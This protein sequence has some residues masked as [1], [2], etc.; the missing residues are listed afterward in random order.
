MN[1]NNPDK[2]TNPIKHYVGKILGLKYFYI[3]SLVLF[4][5]GAHFYN[6]YSTKVYEVNSTI[7]P[8]KESR[9]TILASDN[10]FGASN[11]I[12]PRR[13]I[14]DDVNNLSSYSLIAKTLD[15]LNFEIAYY[16][17]NQGFLK[18]TSEIYEMA[19]FKVT[20][21]KS[22]T[23]PIGCRMYVYPISDSTYLLRVPEQTVNLYNYIDDKV[24]QEEL[25]LKI[26]TLGYY[27]RT[28]TGNNFSF[29]IAHSP[30]G[31]P[32]DTNREK[33]YFFRFFHPDNLAMSYLNRLD[34]RPISF[35]ASI[36]ELHFQGENIDKSITFLNSYI[37]AFMEENLAK[38]NK[39]ALNTVK[40]IDSQLSE[41]S[42]SLVASESMLRNFRSDNQVTDLGFQGERI[43][44]Q[45]DQIDQERSQLEVRKRYFEYVINYFKT[46]NDV[47]GVVPPV[48]ANIT[49]PIMNDLITE[50]LD[51]NS[52]R[53][54]LLNS[55][56][57][58]NLYLNQIEN[59]IRLQKELI[60]EN[61]RNNLNTLNLSINELE[62]REDKLSEEISRLPRTEMNMVGIERKFN[63][64]DAI[65]TFLLEKRSEAAITL[66][67]NFPDYEILEAARFN[68]SKVI[69]PK[70]RTNYMLAFML[71]L[72]VP[73]VY[74]LLR[75]MFDD[76][77]NSTWDLSARS[78]NAVLNK[79]YS[80]KL[81][82]E[83]VFA[84]A[85]SSAIAESFRSMRSH[86]IFKLK[87]DKDKVILVTSSQ[88][89]DGKSFISYN[90][91]IALASVGYKTAIVDSDLRRPTMHR[92]FGF[93]NE[94]GIS[95]YMSNSTG[96][97]E[98]IRETDQENLSV[99]TAGPV[100][101]NASE[102]IQKGE[103]DKLFEYLKSEFDYIIIDSSP[104]G[105]VSDA[106]QLL[107]Y[108]NRVAVVARNKYT[109]KSTFQTAIETLER[110][111]VDD[112]DIVFNDLDIK[113]S[114]YATY[115]KYYTKN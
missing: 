14:E 57:E 15:K 83:N 51:L 1:L 80:N 90:L 28:L 85:P 29:S 49:D 111:L 73:S 33:D 62:Y 45:L 4:L 95:T 94:K 66:A 44:D 32:A 41:I 71:G 8:V 93:E 109:R 112:Y 40:F 12:A 27:N 48:S 105:L 88:P 47:K 101:P 31:K 5:A 6:K 53:S 97:N 43:Y 69:K 59:K 20:M 54:E 99:I 89:K 16:S 84:T 68:S 103:L 64:N 92:K 106:T 3:F 25:V 82:T 55:S 42:D 114:P 63:L 110:Y 58:K 72:M 100:L 60:T 65:Y 22:H 87:D 67:S 81:N 108:S 104:L 30:S 18:Q 17:E 70:D 13:N 10:I 37:N 115:S 50:L 19:P 24:L 46:N 26:D 9:T 34:I 79:I 74:L 91:G 7:G 61:A 39:I 2:E 102:L 11:N 36:I 52:Q 78:G 77:I 96:I 56:S 35:M 21:D 113:K 86:L 76:K 98:I 38:K 23:Q 75:E 107:R